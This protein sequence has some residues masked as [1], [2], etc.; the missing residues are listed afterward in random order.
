MYDIVLIK[1]DAC[2][3]VKCYCAGLFSSAKCFVSLKEFGSVYIC[4][5][6]CLTMSKCKLPTACLV[7]VSYYQAQVLHF[8]GKMRSDSEVFGMV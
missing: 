5:A 7:T 4:V 8:L 6:T 1:N 2:Y 3:C